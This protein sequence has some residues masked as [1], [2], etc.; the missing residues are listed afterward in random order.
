MENETQQL[1]SSKDAGAL[2]YVIGAIVLVGTIA[3][4]VLFWPKTTTPQSVTPMTETLEQ[5]SMI[6]KLSCEK[7]WYNSMIGFS[8]YY[9]SAEG[10]ALD[11]TTMVDC[12]FNVIG[13]DGKLLGSEKQ[14]AV[15]TAL[16]DRGGRKFTC[17]TKAIELPK[18][19]QVTLMTT[20]TDDSGVTANCTPAGTT[21]P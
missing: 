21:L 4:A 10:V 18:G 9:L 11:T 16:P 2:V 3:A 13:L 12:A 7:Q 1:S 17:T 5:K 19:S 20:I 6:T 8:K 14:P 15:V